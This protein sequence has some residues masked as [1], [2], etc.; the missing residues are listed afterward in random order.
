MPFKIKA[1]TLLNN[2][3]NKPED[4]IIKRFLE[5]GIP[6]LWLKL[7]SQETQRKKFLFFKKKK[8]IYRKTESNPE[9]Y[10]NCSSRKL[11]KKI[12]KK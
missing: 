8:K 6:H 2:N 1:R 5:K 12:D 10:F 4:I 9:R 7:T 11:K 3:K